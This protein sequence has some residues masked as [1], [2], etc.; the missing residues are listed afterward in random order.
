MQS[1]VGPLGLVI[2]QSTG[3]CNI[4]CS[5]CYLPDRANSRQTM[6]FS[7][8]AEVARLIFTSK[9]LK[10]DLDMVWHAG[11]P[12]TLNASYY[13]EA[14]RIIEAARPP[15][16]AVHY[17]MQTN[18]TLIS[19]AWIDLFEE[20][21]IKVGVSLDGPRDLHDRHR[22]YRNGS[23]SHDRVVAGIAKLQARH[24]PFHF[25]GVVTAQTLSRAA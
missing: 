3:F 7:T 9:L 19:D 10:R 25:I 21:K 18:G 15:D 1:M 20:H 6:D 8:V 24:Y 2:L 14:I 17:G 23:G 12:M 16:I 4:D 13:R 5:Y 11:E 22:K